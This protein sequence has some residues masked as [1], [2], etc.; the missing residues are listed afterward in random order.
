MAFPLFLVFDTKCLIKPHF[1]SIFKDI[2]PFLSGQ[3]AKKG[4]INSIY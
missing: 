1:F 4:I 2:M 3:V